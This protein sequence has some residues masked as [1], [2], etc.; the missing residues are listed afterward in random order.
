MKKNLESRYLFLKRLAAYSPSVLFVRNSIIKIAKEH[1]LI[2]IR[3]FAYTTN[4]VIVFILVSSC[5]VSV[6]EAIYFFSTRYNTRIKLRFSSIIHIL[7]LDF[8]FIVIIRFT[9]KFLFQ[10][11][12]KFMS[13]LIRLLAKFQILIKSISIRSS[14]LFTIVFL[15]RVTRNTTNICILPITGSTFVLDR[16]LEPVEIR[17][18][19]RPLPINKG[20][21]F[22]FN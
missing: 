8:N 4:R 21:P 11:I 19:Y 16:L 10:S 15:T 12:R 18:F 2:S 17:W 7:S 9:C 5:S 13:S 22:F 20:G 6:I 1:E 14:I 3:G